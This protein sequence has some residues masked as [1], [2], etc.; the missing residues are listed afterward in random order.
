MP[1]FA[2]VAAA[3]VLLA[4][5]ESAA[6]EDTW[7][8][9]ANL[10][11]GTELRV[12]KSGSTQPLLVKMDEANG[13]RIV[14]IKGKTQMAIRKEDI[15]RLDFRPPSKQPRVKRE[16]RIKTSDPGAAAQSPGKLGTNRIPHGTTESGSTLTF[17]NKPDFQT[18]YRRVSPADS[19]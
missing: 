19:K 2:A 18:I 17:G 12:Y 9:V 6:N 3:I 15:T 16:D 11:S 13:D 8:K 1:Q 4:Q 14:V 10:D 7:W 5:Q